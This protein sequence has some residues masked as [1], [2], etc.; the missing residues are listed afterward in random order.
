M[1]ISVGT[2]RGG[3]RLDHELLRKCEQRDAQIAVVGLGYAGLPLALLFAEAGFAVVGIDIDETR[4]NCLTQRE[5]Y[6]SHVPAERIA[7]VRCRTANPFCATSDF[8]AI[9]DADCVL[10]CVQPPLSP[11]GEPDLSHI[12]SA[13]RAIAPFVHRGALVVLE[14]TTYPGTTDDVVRPILEARGLTA[15]VDFFLAYSPER[16]DPCN[17]DYTTRDIPKVIGGHSPACLDVASKLYGMVVARTIPV[18]GLA[19]AEAT[20]LLENIYR[21]V[22]I[23]L[24]NE[25]K[26]LYDRM[27]IDIWEVIAAAASKPFGFAPFY[28]GPGSGGHCIPIDPSYL[29]WK[30]RQYNMTAKFA[31]LATEINGA[32]PLYVADRVSSAL[33]ERGK[34]M[35][36]ARVLL[37][38]LAYKR[39]VD[40]I[41]ESPSLKIY[42]LLTERGAV[43]DYTDPHVPVAEEIVRGGQSLESVVLTEETLAGYDCVV[44]VTD[45]SA[46]D[47]GFIRAHAPLIV[48][49]RNFFHYSAG[50]PNLIRA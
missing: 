15:G 6:V 22:N 30:A 14:S 48:D 26:V 1:E 8:E 28:P 41:R 27:G 31:D 46:F 24:I 9:A 45:H 13:T 34:S 12:T 10:I 44:M 43:V 20:K 33:R 17:T 38:G 29:A 35:P 49:T 16:E 25:I 18:S 36:G 50:E 3:V 23:A 2:G 40:D 32:M 21:A 42:D 47:A 19:V 11:V 5:S 39:N 4:V 7:S 37:L